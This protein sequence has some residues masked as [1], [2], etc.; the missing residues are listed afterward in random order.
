M[1]LAA[2]GGLVND[3][4]RSFL[5]LVRYLYSFNICVLTLIL[6]WGSEGSFIAFK[7]TSEY[8]QYW[9]GISD[10]SSI[11]PVEQQ[12]GNTF[13]WPFRLRG[14]INFFSI[15]FPSPVSAITRGHFEKAKNCLQAAGG[16]GLGKEHLAPYSF[17]PTK[18]WLLDTQ[19]IEGTTVET[20]LHICWWG[21]EKK[22][23]DFK[24]YR[25]LGEPE[26]KLEIFKR[27]AHLE[28]AIHFEEE[29]CSF[30]HIALRN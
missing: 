19:E 11:A 21:S 13:G 29:H 4:K 14:K 8:L 1:S 9:T 15:S 22:E 12:I 20:M 30:V 2:G 25:R 17:P 27:R 7:A 24:E 5:Y 26:N 28:G 3:L 16:V 23:K 10:I 18:L 6:A